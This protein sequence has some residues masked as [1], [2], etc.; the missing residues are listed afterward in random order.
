MISHQV[1]PPKRGLSALLLVVAAAW[2]QG[3]LAESDPSL[4]ATSE[5]SVFNVKIRN[6]TTVPLE[7]LTFRFTSNLNDT[8][9]VSMDSV[10]LAPDSVRAVALVTN[11][12]A[13]RWWNLQVQALDEE[14]SLVALGFAGPIRSTGGI[15]SDTIILSLGARP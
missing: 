15:I 1:V 2:L 14:D 5:R 7:N 9:Q 11:Y 6:E 8:I 12:L 10:A 13:L 4:D 3:C